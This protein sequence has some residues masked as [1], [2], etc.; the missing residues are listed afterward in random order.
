MRSDR[1]PSER[2]VLA[3]SMLVQAILF[4]GLV[5]PVVAV[6]STDGGVGSVVTAELTGSGTI[7]VRAPAPLDIG[8]S[9][10]GNTPT[11]K[12]AGDHAPAGNVACG[13][14]W[15]KNS[16]WNHSKCPGTKCCNTYWGAQTAESCCQQCG[17][18]GIGSEPCVA[19]EWTADAATC[20]VC[21]K[22]VLPFRE[23]MTGHTTGCVGPASECS[24]VGHP[25][26]HQPPTQSLHAHVTRQGMTLGNGTFML[27]GQPIRL[28]A[29]SLQHF[30]M[31]PNHW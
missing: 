25:V 26:V 17:A 9:R 8:A 7:S 6:E 22:A 11:I 23:V 3:W 12:V 13:S 10:R 20:Y 4:S 18:T 19:W 14:N 2:L 24:A 28:F 5:L 30:R 16:F 29:G 1:A 27:D 21:T 15:T 31:H